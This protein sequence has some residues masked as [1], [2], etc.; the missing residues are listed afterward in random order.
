MRR[1]FKALPVVL[2][3]ASLCLLG[4]FAA[5]CGSSGSAKVRLVDAIS[6]GN[7]GLDVDVNG[8]KAFTNITFASPVQP[9]PPAYMSVP[10]GAVTLEAVDTGTTTAV[11]ANTNA[12]FSGSAQYTELMT[13]F[14]NGSGT[15]APTFWTISDNNTAPV[16]GNVEFRIINGATNSIPLSGGLDVYIVQPGQGLGTPQVS[17]LTLGQGSAYITENFNAAGYTVYVTPHGIQNVF[18]NI[19]YQTPTGSIRTLVILD[20]GNQISSFL[21]LNDLG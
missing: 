7:T 21:E 19:T 8:T 3:L 5:S 17:G 16:A 18:F 10:S 12:S 15:S 20:S 6:D 14:T 4:V 9:T 13:G 11:I 1:L 2:S